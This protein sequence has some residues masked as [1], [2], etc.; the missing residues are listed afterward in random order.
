MSSPEDRL[1]ELRDNL[2]AVRSRIA[3]G[4][5]AAGRSEGEITLIAVT[6]FFPVSDAALLAQLGVTDLGESRDQDA[7]VKSAELAALTGVAVRWHFIGRLQ[8]NKA[9]SVARYA[10]LVHSVDRQGLADALED[11]ARRAGRQALDVLVQLSLDPQPGAESGPT[12]R[13][14]GA[15]DE[16][17]RLADRVAAS[18]V[19]RLAGIMAIAPLGGDP[20][21]A[22][23]HLAEVAQRLRESHPAAVIVSAG[24]S[25]DLEAALR[26]GATHVR[27][28][29]A[30]LGRR[31]PQFR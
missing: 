27:I 5:A 21:E 10:D 25:E 7:S 9:R 15:A 31:E 17:L 20:D 30:L 11:G 16:L 23:G 19:L 8:T 26:H 6:K 3:Q 2:A 29:T 12:A 28:G 13:G 24:M 1:A 4:C 22:F 14:G 18:D